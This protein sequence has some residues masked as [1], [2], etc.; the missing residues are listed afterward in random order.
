MACGK[1]DRRGNLMDANKDK[2]KY[3]IRVDTL[4]LE[5]ADARIRDGTARS[6][7]ELIEDAT[8]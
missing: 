5:L 6:C 2:T 4:L 8:D 1:L 7:T 3:F